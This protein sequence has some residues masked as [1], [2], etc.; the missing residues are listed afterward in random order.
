MNLSKLR[1]ARSASE[2]QLSNTFSRQN[3]SYIIVEDLK[4]LETL[5][6]REEA[7]PRK[8]KHERINNQQ[9]DKKAESRMSANDHYN[10]QYIKSGGASQAIKESRSITQFVDVKLPKIN[11]NHN[12]MPK[13][14]EKL[15]DK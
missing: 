8:Q 14:R 15:K 2:S 11:S 10:L 3:K 12:Q 4:L 5:I 9:L 7:Q 13:M 6:S 1:S